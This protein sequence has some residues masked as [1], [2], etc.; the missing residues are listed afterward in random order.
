MIPIVT[1]IN[2][3]RFMNALPLS[4]PVGACALGPAPNCFIHVTLFSSA[5][6]RLWCSPGLP[7]RNIS[8]RRAYVSWMGNAVSIGAWAA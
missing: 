8:T 1:T 2:V 6:L 4:G 5:R 3:L 7:W